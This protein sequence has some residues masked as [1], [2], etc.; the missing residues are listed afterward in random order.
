M[1]EQYAISA[2][3]IFNVIFGDNSNFYRDYLAQKNCEGD[4]LVLTQT[5]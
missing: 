2:T 3:E 5:C 1:D 4:L